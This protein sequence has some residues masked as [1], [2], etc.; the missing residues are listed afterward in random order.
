MQHRNRRHLSLT[1]K[2]VEVV[3]ADQLL[4]EAAS[5]QQAS[6]KETQ[7]SSHDCQEHERLS[8][9]ALNFRTS[10]TTDFT[11]SI[12][13]SLAYRHQQDSGNYTHHVA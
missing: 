8:H 9:P 6:T 3:L 2:G 12:V 5:K 1:A 13:T 10:H 4:L 7:R 11:L